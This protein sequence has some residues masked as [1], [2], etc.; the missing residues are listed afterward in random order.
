MN[1]III[2]LFL[3]PLLGKSQAFFAPA[4]PG[5]VGS[6]GFYRT[7][8]VNH[9]QVPNTDQTN[10]P[11]LVN[12]NADLATVA[13]G[14]LVQN[15][16][17]YDIYFASDVN[18]VSRLKFDRQRWN[19][20][21][22]AAEF[23]VKISNIS[24]VTDSVIYEFYGNPSIT[25]DQSNRTAV[26]DANFSGVYHFGDTLT[27][28]SQTVLDAT[29]NAANMTSNGTW[30][31][32]QQIAGQIGGA[33]QL[34]NGSGDY[35]NFTAPTLTGP[36]TIEGWVNISA[37]GSNSIYF[38]RVSGGNEDMNWF[39]GNLIMY[40]GATNDIVSVATIGA[41]VWHHYAI[42]RSGTSQI[43]YIDGV[44]NAT[45]TNGSNFRIF[46]A[47]GKQGAGTITNNLQI[48][49]TRISVSVRSA[50][51]IKTE[52]NTSTSSTFYSLGSRNNAP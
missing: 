47:I 29:S 30:V 23:W 10:F 16:N 1:K 40:N 49:E 43:M 18:G 48:D 7:I 9:V 36:W 52:Y 34:I 17:G 19:A 5:A 42:T 13:N 46:T 26:W 22:G 27:A 12:G 21:T 28:P 11:F 33:L 24:H 8:T 32:T 31:S 3:F 45:S 37:T 15:A 20:T 25:T 50:D 51:W 44:Q 4:F 35:L 39:G 6:H 41:N 2:I 14:G 38:G